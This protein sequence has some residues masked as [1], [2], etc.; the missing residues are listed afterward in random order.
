MRRRRPGLAAGALREEAYAAA[1]AE[2]ESTLSA[3][4]PPLRCRAE[5]VA[6]SYEWTP[7]SH[8]IAE[9]IDSDTMGLF[10][11]PTFGEELSSADP[12]AP[13][14]TLFIRNILLEADGDMKAFRAEARRTYLHELGHYLGLEEDALDARGLA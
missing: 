10:S 12:H 13:T 11:G 7:S 2:V 5:A 4:P 9:G 3:L 8:L 14:I 6:V 1:R